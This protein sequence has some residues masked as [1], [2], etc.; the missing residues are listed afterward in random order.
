MPHA[1]SI[2]LDAAN[3]FAFAADLGLDKVFVYR[4]NPEG[5][6]LTPDDPPFAKVA[7]SSG[8]GTSSSTPKK[9]APA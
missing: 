6:T 2:N 9:G 3:C 4:F 8:P 1:H 5:E 7:P